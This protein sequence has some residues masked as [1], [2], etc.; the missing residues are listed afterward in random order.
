MWGLLVGCVVS[1]LSA[2]SMDMIDFLADGFD[3]EAGPVEWGS[4]G[5]L[6]EFFDF[7]VE[8]FE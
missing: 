2:G 7:D 4:S 3:D 1:R 5:A 8:V 6:V